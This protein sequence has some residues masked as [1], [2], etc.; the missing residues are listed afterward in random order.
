MA[1]DMWDSTL[2]CYIEKQHVGRYYKSQPK[3]S[4]EIEFQMLSASA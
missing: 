3:L 2:P 1:W 4:L